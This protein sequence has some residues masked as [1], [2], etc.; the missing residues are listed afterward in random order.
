MADHEVLCN[1]CGS[2]LQAMCC[3]PAYI[4]FCVYAKLYMDLSKK[5]IPDQPE[6]PSTWELNDR[7]F[8]AR[9]KELEI[10]DHLRVSKRIVAER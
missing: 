4:Y 9:S 3:F 6:M 2:Q 8:L 10:L 1:L 7:A 5:K